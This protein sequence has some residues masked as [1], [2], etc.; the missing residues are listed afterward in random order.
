[1]AYVTVSNGASGQI[2]GYDSSNA[3]NVTIN[4]QPDNLKT[5]VQALTAALAMAK[6]MAT[7][8]GIDVTDTTTTA[9]STT[10]ATSGTTTTSGSTTGGNTAT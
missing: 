4:L 9:S 10:S 3:S 5:S 7:A 8:F 2:L 1:M 6:N